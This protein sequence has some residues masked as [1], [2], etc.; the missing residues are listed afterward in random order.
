VSKPPPPWARFGARPPKPRAPRPAP[1]K[2]DPK[3][4]AAKPRP[5]PKPGPQSR[6]LLAT[7][8]D[9]REVLYAGPQRPVKIGG[10]YIQPDFEYVKYRKPRGAAIIT[11][12]TPKIQQAG[13]GSGTVRLGDKAIPRWRAESPD[14]P[15]PRGATKNEQKAIRLRRQRAVAQ[16]NLNRDIG[17]GILGYVGETG[18]N[19]AGQVGQVIAAAPMG[20]IGPVAGTAK[21]WFTATNPISLTYANKAEGRAATK[22]IVK[23]PLAFADR[24]ANEQLDFIGRW[25]KD[26]IGT[27]RDEPLNTIGTALGGK[28]VVGSATGAVSRNAGRAGRVVRDIKKEGSLKGA[29]DAR[30][31]RPTK[32]PPGAEKR[33]V[34]ALEGIGKDLQLF[35]SPLGKRA[36]TASQ[37]ASDFGSK[38]TLPGSRRYRPDRVVQPRNREPV[39]GP[40][41]RVVEQ[42]A[43]VSIPR[44]PRSAD[45][46]TRW[47]QR[48]VYERIGDRLPVLRDP[49]RKDG[50]DAGYD[51]QEAVSQSVNSATAPRSKIL[52]AL[53]G[54]G[55]Q[56]PLVVS[57]VDIASA[58]SQ[59]RVRGLTE[60]REGDVTWGKRDRIDRLETTLARDDISP[61]ERARYQKELETYRAIPDEWL[62]PKT[63]PA[64]INKLVDEDTKLSR[65]STESRLASNQIDEY[66]AEV[67]DRRAQVLALGGRAAAT[68]RS[69]INAPSREMRREIVALRT[70]LGRR[71]RG[72]DSLN[73]RLRELSDD[74]I[75]ERL[76]QLVPEWRQ[77]RRAARA[78]TREIDADLFDNS[79][80]YQRRLEELRLADQELSR[81]R[82]AGAPRPQITAL[83]ARRAKA[84]ETVT[85]LATSLREKG[86]FGYDRDE[87]AQMEPGN[88]LPDRR[89]R[90][91]GPGF[92]RR[93]LATG[94][95][96]P[97]GTSSGAGM[98][99][100][101][102]SF[103]AGRLYE[104]G[105]V[106]SSPDIPAT[107]F[108]EAE[109]ARIKSQRAAELI[110]R[111]LA[112]DENGE[113]FVGNAAEKLADE[114]PDEFMTVTARQL[115]KISAATIDTPEGRRIAE[116][117]ESSGLPASGTKFAIPKSTYDGW[118]N[119]LGPA[120]TQ[121]GRLWDNI[122]ALW[123]GNVL[124]LSP[125]WYIINMVGMWGQFALGA[126]ADLQAISMARRTDL[127]NSM[128]A[129]IT[130]RGLSQEMGEAA[131][132][133]SG[134]P[135]RNAYERIITGGFQINEILEAVPRRA[136]FWHAARQGLREN[137]LI[138]PG[139]VSEARLAAAWLDVAESAARGDR[140]A[141]QIID[142]AILVTERF[143]G[144]Y[145]RYNQFEKTVMRRVFPFY[146]W[147]RAIHRL[148]FALPFKHPKR[149]ALLIMG[150]QMAYEM[151]GGERAEAYDRP[152]ALMLGQ[153]L[154]G[155]QIA[156]PSESLRDSTV[157]LPTRFFERVSR[158]TDPRDSVLDFVGDAAA[159]PFQTANDVLRSSARQAGPITGEVLTS[160]YGETPGGIPLQYSPFAQGKVRTP[161]RQS[162]SFD[163][164][165]G[166]ARYD[167]PNV[168]YLDR[169]VRTFTPQATNV[170]RFLADGEPYEDASMIDLFNYW[171]AG[172]PVERTPFVVRN[173]SQYGSPV[174][175]GLTPFLTGLTGFPVSRVDD[176]S[177]YRKTKQET[178][179]GKQGFKSDARRT[180]KGAKQARKKR[181]KG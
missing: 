2:S 148:G 57:Q 104:R 33:F 10:R 64:L 159:L 74:E 55:R 158:L 47:T 102:Q 109:N 19:L 139:P 96:T 24:A 156:N 8:P 52:R 50:S 59:L 81:A 149:A 101:A 126:G 35:T 110:D 88:Y 12:T 14:R 94:G 82:E 60:P 138:G 165:T 144:N 18:Q 13:L 178:S 68:A 115:A 172:R 30:K 36:Y 114:Y 163:P 16:R 133:S 143:M 23:R 31:S 45:P 146:G 131:R 67:S 180:K 167:D 83:A 134:I 122:N 177:L 26:P 111:H 46:I 87:L 78:Q 92:I 155:M 54:S 160:I 125:R 44:R 80:L 140:G 72:E 4:P 42:V 29:R 105:D 150:S 20:I 136:M 17:G 85:K 100:R 34:S 90:E 176:R 48:N 164:N 75:A 108:L 117:V 173:E 95:R 22:N 77:S 63:A 171:R 141:N 61:K 56:G 174:E 130:Y 51:A 11:G 7:A 79:P 41:G 162:L 107:A 71:E 99:P 123:K 154:V 179:F 161:F 73:T 65:R 93:T 70:E 76:D 1:K 3:K 103:N 58:A 28:A 69:E 145:S 89:L 121:A 112:R 135:G 175:R 181:K 38:S 170:R 124:A 39:V 137:D 25:F 5:T 113:P 43:P 157:D 66:T 120:K 166:G 62:D 118:V 21:D 6:G 49:R 9:G 84:Q 97:Y 15:M 86:Y 27:T 119:A 152:G 151:Y 129:R 98:A 147:M 142:E 153:R 127:L 169:V 37:R 106:A 168:D 53:K 116:A 91:P 40:G 132:R 128:P 32:P